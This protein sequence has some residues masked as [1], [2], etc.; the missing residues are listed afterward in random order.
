MHGSPYGIALQGRISRYQRLNASSALP[1][2]YE[3]P[4][5]FDLIFVGTSST[6]MHIFFLAEGE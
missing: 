3:F 4:F 1:R 5:D 6:A 2:S